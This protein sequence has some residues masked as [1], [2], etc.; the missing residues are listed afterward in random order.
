MVKFAEMVKC[1]RAVLRTGQ[2]QQKAQQTL[3]FFFAS[4]R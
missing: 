3:G 1:S 2:E 4:G